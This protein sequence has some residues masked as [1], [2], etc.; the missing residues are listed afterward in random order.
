[1]AGLVP[2]V[3]SFIFMLLEFYGVHLQQLSS[4]SLVLVAIF[5]HFYEMLVCVRPS[6]SLFRLF[7]ML[8][9]CGK[10][11]GLINDY[12]FQLQV[13]GS[14]TYIAPTSPVKWDRWRE[15]WVIV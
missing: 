6:V 11:S 1:V 15:D 9:W 3:S 13:K 14:I 2:P 10:G 12:Y 4:H 7:H 8:R 5:V